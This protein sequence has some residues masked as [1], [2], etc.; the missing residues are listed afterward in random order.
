MVYIMSIS[1]S[2]AE[3]FFV[4]FASF[5]LRAE[6]SVVFQKLDSLLACGETLDSSSSS[7]YTR[8]IPQCILG[9]AELPIQLLQQ[10][11]LNLY[12]KVHTD[13]PCP[14]V[15]LSKTTFSRFGSRPS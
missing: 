11:S 1:T 4:K 12:V 6:A 3:A 13:L 10:A 2:Q 14:A 8:V 5:E 15:V 7:L 9:H